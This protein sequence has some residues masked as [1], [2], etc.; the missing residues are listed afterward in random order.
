MLS[1]NKDTY[2]ISWAS[3][4]SVYELPT[5]GT[6]GLF[7][8]NHDHTA[9]LGWGAVRSRHKEGCSLG[10]S[11]SSRPYT[12][13]CGRSQHPIHLDFG[14]LDARDQHIHESGGTHRTD[15]LRLPNLLDHRV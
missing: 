5:T 6:R 3:P 15:L 9:L 8:D 14:D 7:P 4:W 2:H 1:T 13:E 11:D 12:G 10:N